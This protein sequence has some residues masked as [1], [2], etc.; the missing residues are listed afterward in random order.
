MEE[1]IL[2]PLLRRNIVSLVEGAKHEQS[3]QKNRKRHVKKLQK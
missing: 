1:A 3:D 2:S